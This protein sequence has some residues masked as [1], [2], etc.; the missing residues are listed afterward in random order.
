MPGSHLGGLLALA[1]MGMVA[2]HAGDDIIGGR[3]RRAPR[4]EPTPAQQPRER[5]AADE[6]R[7]QRAEAKRRRK[8][9]RSALSSEQKG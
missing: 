1:A 7:I 8:A 6:Q 2:D 3:E 5:T 9:G 4:R